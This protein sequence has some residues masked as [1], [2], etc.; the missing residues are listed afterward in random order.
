MVAVAIWGLC[1]GASQH[2]APGQIGICPIYNGPFQVGT[3]YGCALYVPLRFGRYL[4]SLFPQS[5]LPCIRAE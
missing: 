3:R 1:W 4:T 5:W 2:R